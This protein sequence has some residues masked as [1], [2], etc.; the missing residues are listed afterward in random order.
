[1]AI[2][3]ELAG[4]KIFKSPILLL[5]L[6]AVAAFAAL[7]GYRQVAQDN[8]RPSVYAQKQTVRVGYLRLLSGAPLYTAVREGYFAD[9]RL[10]V[11]LRVIKS[12]PEGNEALAAGNLDIAFSILPSLVVARAQGVPSD[13]VSFFGASVD[14]PDILDHRIIVTNASRIRVTGDLAGKKIA[15]VGWPGRTSDVLELLDYLSRHDIDAKDVT[16]V[17]MAHAEMVAALESGVVDAAAAAE[18]YIGIGEQAGKVKTLAGTDG[19]YYPSNAETE[20]T[21]YVARKSWIDANKDIAQR[22]TRA[23]ERGRLKAADS[24]WLIKQGLPSFNAKAR[25]PIDFVEISAAQANA[26]HIAPVRLEVSLQGLQHVAEQLVR[27]GPIKQ[28]PGELPSL[29]YRLDND[30][31]KSRVRN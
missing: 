20:V 26:L 1:M 18:P 14:G 22:F 16:L 13:L 6:L 31:G 23:L 10:N 19:F 21:T 8:P 4:M 28:A 7:L 25:P 24:D 12:G 3:G 15:V 2:T 17:G 29:R 9:E 27:Y 5:A 30:A 11:E